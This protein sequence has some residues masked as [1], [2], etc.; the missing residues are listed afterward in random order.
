MDN[1]RVL[2]GEASSTYRDAIRQVLAAT[3]RLVLAA[4]AATD[5][6]VVAEALRAQPDVALVDVHLPG[7][8]G[9][10]VARELQ[11]KV[12]N[13]KVVMLLSDDAPSYRSAA[14]Q[15]GARW[16][17]KD[18]LADELPR[19]VQAAAVESESWVT[20]EGGASVD[21]MKLDV[22]YGGQ[23]GIG[24]ARVLRRESAWTGSL[25][26]AVK[27]AL[28]IFLVG[29]ILL[30]LTAFLSWDLHTPV[31][32]DSAGG[33]WVVDERGL[34]GKQ[35]A[36]VRLNREQTDS[37]ITTQIS[38]HRS[39]LLTCLAVGMLGL[40]A[41]S[42]GIAWYQVKDMRHPAD[43]PILTTSFSGGK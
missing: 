2:I 32:R 7:R 39:E 6:E 5:S 41:G 25:T 15:V 38:L 14:A 12:P 34:L 3:P 11:Q 37:Y 26:Q 8:S 23:F 31:D 10:A 27:P 29:V 1:L 43:T 36:V 28:L 16:A 35:G 21:N 18:R 24:A 13:V 30:G 33:A 17:A 4:E 19:L 42:I 9:L 20:P 40:V 22:K